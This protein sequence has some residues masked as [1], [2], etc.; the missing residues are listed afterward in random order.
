MDK[1]IPLS[2]DRLSDIGAAHSN[3]APNRVAP[4]TLNFFMCILLRRQRLPHCRPRLTHKTTLF[5]PEFRHPVRLSGEN[6]P[7]GRGGYWLIWF[8]TSQRP[9]GPIR[10]ACSQ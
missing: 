9:V 4:I 3:A 2:W 5:A 6:S 10:L 1:D 8:A 7:D